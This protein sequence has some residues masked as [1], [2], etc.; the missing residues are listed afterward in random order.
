M[1]RGVWR[2]PRR[3]PPSCPG[4][5]PA[6]LRERRPRQCRSRTPVPR[7]SPARPCLPVASL[8]PIR[9][10]L[11]SSSLSLLGDELVVDLTGPLSGRTGA[12]K[13]PIALKRRPL[14]DHT[15]HHA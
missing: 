11:P 15:V 7:R 10:L 8:S 5:P 3:L 13:P 1:D 9:P 2:P 4:T 14:V 12:H 6:R